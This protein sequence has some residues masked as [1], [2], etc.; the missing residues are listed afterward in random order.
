MLIKLGKYLR[1]LGYDA[2]W[3][4]GAS[5]RDAMDRAARDGRVFVTRNTHIAPE[6]SPER[7]V[8]RVAEDDPAVQA[9]R[10]VSELGLD[11]RTRLF[12]RC[13]RCNVELDRIAEVDEVRGRVPESVLGWCRAFYRCPSCATVFWKGSH[14]AN[15]CRKLGLPAPEDGA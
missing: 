11:V 6:R 5:S 9:W 14:V 2:V 8:V 15:T 1:C 4:G 10:V 12:T 13:I 7:R 3:D